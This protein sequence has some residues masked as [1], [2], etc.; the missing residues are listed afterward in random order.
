MGDL[1]MK[2]FVWSFGGKI[3]NILDLEKFAHV[4]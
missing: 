1:H 3:K 2:R 4:I